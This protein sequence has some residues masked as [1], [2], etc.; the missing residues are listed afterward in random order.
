MKLIRVIKAS[1]NSVET[2]VPLFDGFYETMF[3]DY[4]QHREDIGEM[5]TDEI[6]GKISE[7]F[8]SFRYTFEKVISPKQ[9]NYGTD[10]IY[11]RADFDMNEIMNYLSSNK[12]K[13]DSYAKNN[14]SSYD[15]FISFLPNNYDEFVENILKAGERELSSF[16]C[17]VVE[18][19]LYNNFGDGIQEELNENVYYDIDFEKDISWEVDGFSY[20]TEEEARTAFQQACEEE[21]SEDHV[22]MYTDGWSDESEEVEFY[23]GK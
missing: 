9:Y 12:D 8:P 17:G 1:A 3:T 16:I 19:A 2:I 20:D 23:K 6:N 10:E 11:A 21:P 22:L 14:F 5:F 18:F 15:G 7:I 4:W 13:F